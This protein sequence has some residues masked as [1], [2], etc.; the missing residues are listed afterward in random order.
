MNGLTALF[1]VA[2]V[3]FFSLTL[4]ALKFLDFL[5]S[6]FV[7][8][9]TPVIFLNSGNST[10]YVWALAFILASCFCCVIEQPVLAG[11][12]LGLAIGCRITSAAMIV[13]LSLLLLQRTK[14]RPW[15]AVSR[16]AAAACILSALC[17]APVIWNYGW[18]WFTFSEDYDPGVVEITRKLTVDTWGMLGFASI[19][20]SLGWILLRPKLRTSLRDPHRA[21]WAIAVALYLAAFLRLPHLAAYLIPAIPFTILLL[22]SILPR[23]IFVAVS[24]AVMLSSF[25]T[26]GRKGISSPIVSDYRAR[27]QGVQSVNQIFARASTLPKQTVIIA[28]HW[29]P[30]ILASRP[31][32]DRTEYVWLL[33]K[34]QIEAYANRGFTLY[35]LPDQRDYSLN[36]YHVDPAAYGVMP[37]PVR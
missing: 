13:P 21:V 24:C 16:F 10:D 31:L 30:Q 18:S 14:D 28:G 3:L 4:H 1:S 12:C 33:N 32:L 25:I 26:I 37:L 6:G 22:G 2:A 29:L 5:L 11:A 19:V 15:R 17:F 35:Y 8:A 27:V 23:R 7:L 9:F 20:I 34:A 36:Y